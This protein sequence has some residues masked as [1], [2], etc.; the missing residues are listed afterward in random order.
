MSISLN[1]HEERIKNAELELPKIQSRIDNLVASGK[2]YAIY[3]VTGRSNTTVDSKWSSC[4]MCL[5]S[6]SMSAKISYSTDSGGSDVSTID[7]SSSTSRINA[8]PYSTASQ[9]R[10]TFYINKNGTTLSISISNNE[11]DI[12][13]YRTTA[14]VLL[15]K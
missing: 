7:V 14:T 8:Y 12:N 5:I 4:K 15:Y 11:Y 3:T 1:N 2:D 13:T 9:G 10:P 6:C